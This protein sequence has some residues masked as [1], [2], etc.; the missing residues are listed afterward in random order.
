MSAGMNP[1]SKDRRGLTLLEVLIA[2]LLM[3]VI[4]VGV[5]SLYLAGRKFYIASSE[6]V[7]IG[8]ESQY[9]VQ[10]IYKYVMRGIGDVSAPP[11]QITGATQLDI[12]INENDPLTSANYAS[13]VVNYRYRYDSGAK[14]IYFRAGSGSE[15]D[16]IPKVSVTDVNFTKSGN[17]LTGYITAGYGAQSLTF[18]FSCYPRLATFR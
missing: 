18:Y 17:A 11:F 9:A 13:G 5:S 16:L 4:F 6:K 12:S 15:E 3:S 14:K 8:S 7:I 10:H 1:L 2:V